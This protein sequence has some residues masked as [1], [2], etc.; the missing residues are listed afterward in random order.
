[1]CE[2]QDNVVFFVALLS[3]YKR[4]FCTLFTSQNVNKSV[5]NQ[6][7]SK[8]PNLSLKK[9]NLFPPNFFNVNNAED[10]NKSTNQSGAQARNI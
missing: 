8:M 9:P 1:M 7:T 4:H 2:I 3:Q 5:I 6:I 10:K